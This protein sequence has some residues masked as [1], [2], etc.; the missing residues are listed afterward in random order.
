MLV[1]PPG[2]G[3]YQGWLHEGRFPDFCE[4]F[5]NKLMIYKS[6]DRTDVKQA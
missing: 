6:T 1:I 4:G 3:K 2:D 5:G